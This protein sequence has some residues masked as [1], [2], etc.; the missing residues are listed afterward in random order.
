MITREKKIMPFLRK[1]ESR[2]LICLFFL[3]ASSL[4]AQENWSVENLSELPEALSNNP[5]STATID[6]VTYLY[7]F[8]GIDESK[9]WAGIHNRAYRMNMDNNT[10][11]S[12]PDLPMEVPVIAGGASSCAN[13]IY[14]LGGYEVNMFGQEV[15]SDQIFRY[16]PT[17]NFY[18]ERSNIPTAI[19]DHVQAVYKDSLIFVVTGWSNNGNVANVQIYNPSSDTWS[20]GTPLPNLN[21]YATF[22]S[23]G[24][25]IGDTI[26]YA[27]GASVLGFNFL[28]QPLLRKGYIHPEDP[29]QVDWF[30]EEHEHALGYRMASFAHKG[31]IYWVGGSDVAYNY[32]GIAYSD[33]SGVPATSSI[34]V[35]DPETGD[36]ERYEEQIPAGM[37]YRGIAVIEDGDYVLI[38]GMQ[39]EQ[40]VTNRVTRLKNDAFLGLEETASS[41]LLIKLVSARGIYLQDKQYKGSFAIY[42]VQG[43]LL[44]EGNAVNGELLFSSP[45]N[46][47][48][49]TNALLILNLED[50]RTGKFYAY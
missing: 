39:E 4:N 1:M 24:E 11:E 30:L 13:D 46:K 43:K 27:G 5:V 28:L 33:G 41:S 48:T 7:T 21:D 18:E 44:T 32:D 22:G 23:S 31:K 47:S 17:L 29:K 36:I 19:D 40:T 10:W 20:E 49:G 15:S 8:G 45:I 37:D 12:I 35:Y 50:G 16:N 38:G 26:Y 6:G 3:L 2:L 42:D 34:R 9:S 14:V 25:I